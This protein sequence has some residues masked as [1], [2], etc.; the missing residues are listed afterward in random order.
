MKQKTKKYRCIKCKK[1]I[2]FTE[3]D[4]YGGMCNECRRRAIFKI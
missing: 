4:A 1:R 2:S 3:Y